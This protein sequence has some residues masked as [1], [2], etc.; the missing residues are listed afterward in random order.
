VANERCACGEG[1]LWHPE[2]RRLYWIDIPTGTLL[3]FDPASGRHESCQRGGVIGGLTLQADGSLLLFLERGAVKVWREGIVRTI[4]EEIPE[5][6][7]SRFNDCIADPG[8]RV[9]CGTMPSPGASSGSLYR[10][11]T[12]GRVRRLLDGIAC[13]NGLGFTPDRRGLYYADSG[14]REIWC[15]DFDEGTGGIGN[16]RVFARFAEG[17]IPDGLTVD[18]EGFVWC[19]LFAAGCVVRLDPDGHERLRIPV[20][21]RFA[22]SVAF[23]G[24]DLSDL[25]VTTGGGDDRSTNGRGAGALFRIRGAGQGVAE[26]RSRIGL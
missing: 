26:F 23:G 21:A 1:P 10:L 12:D 3:R 15:F 8:G 9:L 5:E 16:R 25:Y 20:A 4:L 14:P 17:E 11:G 18:A 7:A 22:T 6:R 19:A 2:Q 13:T 24:E